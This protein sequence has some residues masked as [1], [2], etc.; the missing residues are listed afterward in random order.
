M[1]ARV[2]ASVARALPR[3]TGGQPFNND[4]NS[5]SNS[6]R[7]SSNNTSNNSSNNSNNNNSQGLRGQRGDP[8]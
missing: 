2:P 6:N 5:T 7:S 4:K 8:I 1:F 3:G